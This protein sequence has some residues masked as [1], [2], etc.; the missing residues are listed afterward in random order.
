MSFTI[1]ILAALVAL[2]TSV[3]SLFN[4]TEKPEK[5]NQRRMLLGFAVV[6]FAI[7]ITD[8]VVKT[9]DEASKEKR[10]QEELAALQ[11]NFEE[12]R[13]QLDAH[14]QELQ[15]E[16]KLLLAQHT[17]VMCELRKEWG[18]AGCPAMSEA[19]AAQLQKANHEL[20]R[21]LATNEN[22][23]FAVKVQYFAKDLD[24]KRLAISLREAGFEEVVRASSAEKMKDVATNAIFYGPGVPQEAVRVLSLALMRAGVQLQGI[25]LTPTLGKLIQVGADAK[26][27][28]KPVVTPETLQQRISGSFALDNA[29]S[30]GG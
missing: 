1:S 22:H 24:P 29:G 14:N 2:A 27:V 4:E 20:S 11:K 12:Q 19:Q 3:Y 17:E 21:A 23:K 9:V 28:D 6:A 8:Q 13:K 5:R 26:L 25:K 30:D 18:S 16:K 7:S 15:A 10:H